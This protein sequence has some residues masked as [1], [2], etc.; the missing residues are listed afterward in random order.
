MQT[1]PIYVFED[2][3]E[4]GI[5]EVPIDSPIIFKNTIDG[6]T[7]QVLKESNDGLTATTTVADFLTNN[8]LYT[9][10]SGDVTAIS[11]I[12]EIAVTSPEDGDVMT[13]DQQTQVWT[14][15]PMD[16]GTF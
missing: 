10:M 8:S 15:K 4:L 1:K 9:Y 6:K 3:N 2:L 14:N 7:I 13:Y 16:G 11:D 12:E 5:H